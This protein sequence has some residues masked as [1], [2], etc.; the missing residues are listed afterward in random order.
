MNNTIKNIAIWIVID[1]VLMTLFNQFA[2]KSAGEVPMI[3][4]Q[5]IQEVKQGRVAKVTI[6]GRVLRGET[7]DSIVTH[8][9]IRA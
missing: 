7:N 6:E 1:I 8:P 4:S 2:S 3:Y 9:M 5:F